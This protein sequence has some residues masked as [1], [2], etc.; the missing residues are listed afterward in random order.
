MLKYVTIK[1]KREVGQKSLVSTISALICVR[2][3]EIAG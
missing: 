1:I 3:P 2:S